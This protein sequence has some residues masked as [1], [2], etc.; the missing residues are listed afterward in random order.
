MFISHIA[1]VEISV[2]NLD[3]SVAFYVDVL[4]VKVEFKEFQ[5][6]SW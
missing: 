3:R 5:Q 1:T 6:S 2:S 4:G